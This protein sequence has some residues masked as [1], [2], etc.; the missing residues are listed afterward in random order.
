MFIVLAVASAAVLFDTIDARGFLASVAVGLAIIY[1]GGIR[2]FIV[3]AVFFILG[4]VF[5][6]YRY[7]YKKALGGAQDKG[8]ARNWPNIIA[9]GGVS[10][11]IA[12][13][14][15]FSSS[16]LLAVLFLG[17]VSGSAADTAA[18]EV[19][20]LSR[21]APRLI[22]DPMKTVRPGTS[23]GVSPLGFL[24]AGFAAG[25]IGTIA[26]ALGVGPG[27]WLVVFVCFLS[28]LVGAVFDSI[29]GAAVQ[30]T[31]FCRV[32]LKPSEALRH[33]GE[34][35]RMN[36]G[37]RFIENNVVNLAATGVGALAAVAAFSLLSVA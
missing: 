23:G 10:S 5:T 26:L 18:T 6:L 25:V 30:R 15:F 13:A 29:L 32:C 36:A 34:P 22:T 11:V 7:G 17:A 20:L 33:C 24:G 2:W 28:G 35:T 14:S 3:V 31:G 9:N 4:V 1:G 12:A 37:S 16:P 21:M 19:G 8:G 27:G